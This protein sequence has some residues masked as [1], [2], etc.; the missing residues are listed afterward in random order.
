[1]RKSESRTNKS[2]KIKEIKRELGKLGFIKEMARGGK[3]D[4]AGRKPGTTAPRVTRGGTIEQGRPLGRS[5]GSTR[6]VCEVGPSRVSSHRGGKR[7]A[8]AVQG[9]RAQ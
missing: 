9:R 7:R 8:R 6:T 2:K 3:R 4:G 1:M 5:T